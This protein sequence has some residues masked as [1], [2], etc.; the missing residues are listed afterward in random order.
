VGETDLLKGGADSILDVLL[1]LGGLGGGGGGPYGA[2]R[3][4]GGEVVVVVVVLDVCP[5][6]G[7]E[8]RGSPEDILL[9]RLLLLL[10]GPR[11]VL[12][13]GGRPGRPALVALLLLL[14]GLERREHVAGVELH[15]LRRRS[16]P[17][18]PSHHAP[19]PPRWDPGE[20]SRAN[21]GPESES[22]PP[23]DLRGR[24]GA[25]GSS[26]PGDR[27]WIGIWGRDGPM[28]ARLLGF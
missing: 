16:S 28:E 20:A 15:L 22:A 2:R 5:G 10:R 17:P 26:P 27:T 8:R 13:P 23:A 14:E 18:P 19:R 1:L 6:L 24:V 12:L 4:G 25:G 21:H 3:R 7:G 9:R 11:A